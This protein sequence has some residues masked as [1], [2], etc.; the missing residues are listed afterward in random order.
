M[1]N[2]EDA[3]HKNRSINLLKRMAR[4]LLGMVMMRGSSLGTPTIQLRRPGEKSLFGYMEL[5]ESKLRCYKR[6]AAMEKDR[7]GFTHRVDKEDEIEIDLCDPS[8][9]D[10]IK[11]FFKSVLERPKDDLRL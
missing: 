5:K 1:A 3:A 11:E 9:P 8:S 2:K 4:D 6:W 7:L 10:K